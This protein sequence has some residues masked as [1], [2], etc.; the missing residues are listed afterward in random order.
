M[1]KLQIVKN[2]NINGIMCDFYSDGTGEFYM[3]RQQIGEALEYDDPNKQIDKL[4]QRH[5][6][7]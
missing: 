5:K 1:N 4:Y 3:T 6:K 7:D 2:A